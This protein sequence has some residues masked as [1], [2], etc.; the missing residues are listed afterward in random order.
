MN[1]STGGALRRSSVATILVNLGLISGSTITGKS[2]G[3]LIVGVVEN[4]IILSV[5]G[6]AL[7]SDSRSMLPP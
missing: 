4:L 7:A 5:I 2:S 1:E 6:V 3:A